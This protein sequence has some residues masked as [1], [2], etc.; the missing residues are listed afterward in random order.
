MDNPIELEKSEQEV[1]SAANELQATL[2]SQGWQRILKWMDD[3]IE[4]ER[5]DMEGNIST[6]PQLAYRLQLR[7]KERKLMKSSLMDVIQETLDAKKEV[8]VLIAKSRG[9]NQEQAEEFAQSGI[10]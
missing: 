8:L 1:I 6:D 9:A 10:F 3:Y 7:W 2:H 4:L 5:E